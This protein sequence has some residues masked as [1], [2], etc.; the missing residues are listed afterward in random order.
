M[1][2]ESRAFLLIYTNILVLLKSL[3]NGKRYDQGNFWLMFYSK[4]DVKATAPGDLKPK[5]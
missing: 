2:C 4:H 5:F 3:K 1:L